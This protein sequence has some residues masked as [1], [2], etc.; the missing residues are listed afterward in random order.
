M[1]WE[2]VS[3]NL[4]DERD[5]AQAAAVF[6]VFV[7]VLSVFVFFSLNKRIYCQ[8]IVYKPHAGFMVR[9]FTLCLCFLYSELFPVSIKGNV[10]LLHR[11]ATYV[12]G[13]INDA[14]QNPNCCRNEWTAAGDVDKI[15]QIYAP[16]FRHFDDVVFTMLP[17][18][19]NCWSIT[20]RF[21]F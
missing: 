4:I 3:L 6:A 16:N 11:G 8:S 18:T 12:C 15:E 10:A 9:S 2:L 17:V 19:H 14:A 20:H 7:F 5:Q 1:F 21:D 13:Q